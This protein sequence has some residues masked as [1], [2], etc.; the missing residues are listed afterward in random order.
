MDQIHEVEVFR[1]MLTQKGVVSPDGCEPVLT[2]LLCSD[3]SAVVH[4]T[5]HYLT[6]P[7][8]WE[9]RAMRAAYSAL[10]RNQMLSKDLMILTLWGQH[11]ESTRLAYGFEAA[12]LRVRD[13]GFAAFRR[14][15]Y[16]EMRELV[17]LVRS[18]ATNVFC[19]SRK[20]GKEVPALLRKNCV[21]TH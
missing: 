9:D 16:Q 17:S 14:L 1:S 2:G 12:S 8:G 20:E 5:V 15:D 13:L 4:F 19:D 21:K 6:E 3:A 7:K 11:L 10:E 18:K